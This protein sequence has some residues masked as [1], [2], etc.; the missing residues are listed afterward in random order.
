MTA[1]TAEAVDV[2]WGDLMVCTGCGK[3][4]WYSKAKSTCGLCG[5]PGRPSGVPDNPSTRVRAPHSEL[6]DRFTDGGSFILDT[7]PD[8]TPLWG[9]GQ[10]VLWAEGES[11]II[12]GGQGLGKTTLAQ[13]LALA[14]CGFPEYADLLGY[15]VA[16]R[17]LGTVLYMA[18]DRP[19]QAA[20]SFRR[21][22]GEGMRDDLDRLLRIWEGPPIVDIAKNPDSLRAYADTVGAETVIVDSIKDAALGLSDD[23]VGGGWNRARQICLRAG[24]QMIELHHNRKAI[25]GAKTTHPSIDEVYGSTWI[26]SGSGSVVL[27]T[28]SPGDPIVGLHHLKQPASEVGPL[29]V[30]HDHTTGRSSVWHQVDLLALATATPEGVT[31]VQ[32]A[33]VLFDTDK[34]TS[35]EKEKARRKLDRLASD[36]LVHVLDNGDV[37]GNRPK[38]WGL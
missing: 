12:V 17:P 30:I 34:P 4:G 31:A 21:M 24:I 27:L 35:A 8:P 37:V 38:R 19:R 26:T 25:S 5:S 13:Q 36:E 28:G 6:R 33:R 9:A 18:M 10:D 7:P 23:E 29:K 1:E 20:R 22:V 3:G 15:P 11:L 32:A 14:R 2:D 16:W